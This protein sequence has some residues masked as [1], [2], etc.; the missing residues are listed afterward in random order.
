VDSYTVADALA[1]AGVKNTRPFSSM[2]MPFKLKK[3]QVIG[4][5]GCLRNPRFGL[6]FEARTGK[7]IVFQLV[8]IY[9]AYYGVKSVLL[10]PPILFLQFLESWE[11]IEGDKPKV[12]VFRQGPQRRRALLKKWVKEGSPDTLVMTKEI[13]KKHW[14][15]LVSLGHT[16]LTFDESHLGLAKDTT[17]TYR[18]IESF[19]SAPDTR[20][21]L[22]TGTPIP[23]GIEGAYPSVQLLNPGAYTGE[24]H[25]YRLHVEMT[26]IE[27]TNRR[28]RKVLI[29]VPL[30]YKNIGILHANLYKNA[31]RATKS[32]VL[33]IEEPNIQVVPFALS[34]PH[35]SLYKTLMKQRVLEVGD[36][37]ITAVQAQKLRMLAL[38]LISSPNNYSEKPIKNEPLAGLEQLLHSAGIDK[39]EKVAVFAN[40]NESVETV[41]EALKKYGA[42]SVYGKNTQTQNQRNVAAFQE[43]DKCQVLVLNPQAGGVGL[44]LGHVCTSVVFFEPVSSPGIFDQA[45]SRV[46]LEG[47]DKA[48][49]CYIMRIVNTISPRAIEKMLERNV[50]IKQANQDVKSLLDELCIS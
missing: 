33:N 37:M 16:A 32:E 31:V 49:V 3:H 25:F 29:D 23:S 38:R 14:A 34:A 39:G 30:G 13:Y 36:K 10:M 19:L 5:N 28:G 41:T 26:K 15:D 45:M 50:Q 1:E 18:T 47:Q 35:Y 11:E 42:L 9:C 43:T 20:I 6:F 44:K 7:T 4:L 2:K 40:F 24:E 48:V 12:F 27:Q 46:I 22:S 8:S 21:I 17:E